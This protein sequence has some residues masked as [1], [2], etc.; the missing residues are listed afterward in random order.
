MKFHL[1][2]GRMDVHIHGGGGNFEEQTAHRVAP[3]H[4]RGVIAFD[5]REVEAAILHRPAIHKQVLV[6]ARGARHPRR[7]DET[8]E[9]NL[10]FEI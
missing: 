7:A 2:L 4:Q 3:L 5:Q 6:L 8:P 9:V 10:R 1:A